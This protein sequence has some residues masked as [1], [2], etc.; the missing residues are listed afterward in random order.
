MAGP[1]AQREIERR[2]LAGRRCLDCRRSSHASLAL[3]RAGQ[4]G[5]PA[6][7]GTDRQVEW[8]M[9]LRDAARAAYVAEGA[10]LAASATVPEAADCARDAVALVL[11]ERSAAWWIEARGTDPRTEL[12]RRVMALARER[13]LA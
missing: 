10:R 3:V 8:A 7:E 1:M 6:L 4:A 9:R 12:A 2:Q 13:G 5:L 11:G